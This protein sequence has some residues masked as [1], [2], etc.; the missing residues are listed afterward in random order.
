MKGTVLQYFVARLLER[1]GL[2]LDD[3]RPVQATGFGTGLLDKGA[4]DAIVLTE[5]FLTQL[6]DSGKIRII[7]TGARPNTPGFMYLVAS[8]AALADPAKAKAIGDLVARAAR[9]QR[10]QREN[11]KKAAPAIAKRYNVDLGIAER[12][13][14]RSPQHYTPID[15]GVIAA[16]GSVAVYADDG[17][18]P[19]SLPVRPL[20]VANARWQFVLVYTAPHDWKWRAVQDV[21]AAVFAGAVR[22]GEEAGLPLHHFPLER[23]A[24]A[25][26]AVE[27]GAVG[28]V[29]VDVT[30]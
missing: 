10:W 30:D 23:T 13:I 25:H 6:E 27:A 21:S 28:K 16:H 29:L 7:A 12:I 26:A 3:I 9:A 5:P 17:G 15:A 2:S 11:V 4:A 18:A 20:M 24:E 22:V 14:A 8:D 1:E 19:L